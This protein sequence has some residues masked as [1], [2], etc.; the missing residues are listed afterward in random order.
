MYNNVNVSQSKAGTP[1]R[2]QVLAATFLSYF[3][4]CYD[5]IILSIVMPVI[6][7]VLGIS[8][9]QGGL[10][11][12]LS[13]V[14]AMIGSI[15]LGVVAENKGRKFALILSVVWFAVG[16]FPVIFIQHFAHFLNNLMHFRLIR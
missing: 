13:M 7:N 3:A 12:S 1:Q 4:E 15:V 16:T 5:L 8:L 14:G 10:L 6:I 2:W 9:A 11:S